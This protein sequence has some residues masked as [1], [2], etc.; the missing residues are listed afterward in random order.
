ML[1]FLRVKLKLHCWFLLKRFGPESFLLLLVSSWSCSSGNV[2]AALKDRLLF[3][4]PFQTRISYQKRV[5]NEDHL[6]QPVESGVSTTGH[7]GNELLAAQQLLVCHE[8]ARTTGR[9]RSGAGTASCQ[10]AP[11]GAR[12]PL[13]ELTGAGG[14]TSLLPTSTQLNANR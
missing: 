2:A 6:L 12:T 8:I 13:P 1:Q 14:F 3:S 7:S 11:D 4:R 9:G 5:I 10:A